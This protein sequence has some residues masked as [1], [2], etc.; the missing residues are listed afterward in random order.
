[1]LRRLAHER[2]LAHVAYGAIVDDL[3]DL[4]PGMQAAKRMGVVAPLLEAGIGKHEVRVLARAAGL[5]VAERPANA[6]LA[7]R[8]PAGTEVTLSR[9][10]RIDRA[11]AALRELGLGQLRVRDHGKLARIEL[12]EE[13]LRKVSD[14]VL[15]DRAIRATREAGFHEV[16]VDPTGYRPGGAEPPSA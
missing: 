2:G 13:G 15:L 16:V 11:E 5:P 1:M 8:I 6:C 12:D 7:S 4:R 10:A 3:G 14:P 9:L